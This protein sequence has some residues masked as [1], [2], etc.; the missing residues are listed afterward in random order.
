V[1]CIVRLLGLHCGA[2]VIPCGCCGLERLHFSRNTSN[3]PQHSSLVFELQ[4]GADAVRNEHMQ[5][6]CESWNFGS[7]G[8]PT[9]GNELLFG[10]MRLGT[11]Q[12]PPGGPHCLHMSSEC[13]GKSG[14]AGPRRHATTYFAGDCKPKIAIIL[15]PCQSALDA[16]H[17]GLAPAGGTPGLVC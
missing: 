5:C 2:L 6:M 4:K 7:E 16:S 15:L 12:T 8:I 1:H 11:P 3:I 14:C 9:P 10:Q 13:T 17:R